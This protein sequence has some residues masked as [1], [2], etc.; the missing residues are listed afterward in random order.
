MKHQTFDEIWSQHARRGG[1]SRELEPLARGAFEA[2][3][4]SPIELTQ[5]R[6]TLERLLAFLAS[7]SGR[8]DPN[9]TAIDHFFSLGEFD[10]PDLPDGIHDVLSDI[11]GALHDTVSSPTVAAN[12]ESTPEQLLARL[13]GA[14]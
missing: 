4:A 9:C 12:F 11:A 8:T 10:W 14:S 6:R 1:I 5:L 7:P 3:T 2:L 13:R